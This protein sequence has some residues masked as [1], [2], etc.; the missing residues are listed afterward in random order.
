MSL[1]LGGCG[2]SSSSPEALQPQDP[3]VGQVALL[4]TDLPS[5]DFDQIL[6]R[7]DEVSPLRDE[8]H[9]VPYPQSAADGDMELALLSMRQV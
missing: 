8:G 3:G 2:G 5:D 4:F 7:F 6:I 9:Q 1:L